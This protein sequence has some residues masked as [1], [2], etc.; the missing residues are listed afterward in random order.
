MPRVFAA[1]LEALQKE[2]SLIVT[3][4]GK[5]IGLFHKGETVFAV[6]NYCPHMGAPICRGHVSGAVVSNA[7]GEAD[8][9]HSRAILRCPWHHWEFD[10][11]TGQSLTPIK[12]R[13]KIYEV[14]IENGEVWVE[15]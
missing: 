1:K 11:E 5:E 4:N 7:P 15:L 3:L 8:Y 12:Q 14:Q 13:L 6:L 9:D 10:L 2:K